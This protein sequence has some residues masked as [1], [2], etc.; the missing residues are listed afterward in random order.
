MKKRLLIALLAMLVSTM[1][2]HAQRRIIVFDP[3]LSEPVRA[4]TVWPD[5]N[6]ADT[7]NILGQVSIPEKFDTLYIS[8]SGYVALRIPRAYVEDSI[9]LIR[10][11]NH[12]GEVVVYGEKS[13]N[14]DNAVKH[15]T[16]E[17]QTEVELRNPITGVSFN[18]SDL[19][20][21][22]Q[23][24]DRKHAKQLE[25]VFR[26]MDHDESPIIQSYR[27]ALRK[28]KN[29]THNKGKRRITTQFYE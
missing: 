28:R 22:R 8:K 6:K 1:A 14:L 3:E 5:H 11:Y 7:T 10:D 19:L 25:K 2:L 26:Q 29:E 16:K 21:R 17:E 15:W 4:V 23:R 18:M 27:R 9:P 24:R 20:N 13:D 12:I